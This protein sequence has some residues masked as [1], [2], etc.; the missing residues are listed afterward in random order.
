MARAQAHQ[1]RET[2]LK[3]RTLAGTAAAVLAAAVLAACSSAPTSGK[4]TAWTWTPPTVQTVNVS[5]E[6]WSGQ[7]GSG[8]CLD[9]NTAQLPKPQDC[10]L[11]FTSSGATGKTDLNVGETECRAFLGQHWPIGGTADTPTNP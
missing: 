6:F 9:W 11:T 8:Y 3:T 4:V 5:C 2:P 7:Q 10:A 1:P